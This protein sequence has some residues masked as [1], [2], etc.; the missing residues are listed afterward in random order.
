[1]GS[2]APY[3][4]AM[5]LCLV[6]LRL[7]SSTKCSK[8]CRL[9]LLVRP[10]AGISAVERYSASKDPF[11]NSLSGPQVVDVYVPETGLDALSRMRD[12]PYGLNVIVEDCGLK[13]E[14]FC[15]LLEESLKRHSLLR[16]TCQRQE[17]SFSR[18]SCHS[19]LPRSTLMDRPSIQQEDK[20]LE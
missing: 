18:R 7:I 10:S 16:C 13:L 5:I 14:V 2:P 15:N 20:P 4:F 6:S 8:R 12:Q 9:S 19:V 17:L 11:A 1:M 3:A